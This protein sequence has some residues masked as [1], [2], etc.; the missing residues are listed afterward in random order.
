[1]PVFIVL[2][3]V[4]I[5]VVLVLGGLL[6]KR[7]RDNGGIAPTLKKIR[8]TRTWQVPGGLTPEPSTPP[9]TREP[10]FISDR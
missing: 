8:V 6:G 5:L 7:V 9:Q 10:S 2:G 3:V 1:M 4:G